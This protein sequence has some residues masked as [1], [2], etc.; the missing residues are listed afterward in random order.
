MR[1]LVVGYQGVLPRSLREQSII[2]RP[3]EFAGSLAA[4]V[5]VVLF[6]DQAVEPRDH[7][8]ECTLA[9]PVEADHADVFAVVEREV[10]AVEDAT[11]AERVSET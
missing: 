11:V 3:A 2:V 1:L 7:L 9:A 6:G 5:C 10:D 4:V 8:H